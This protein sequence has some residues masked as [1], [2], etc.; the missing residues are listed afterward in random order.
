MN[1]LDDQVRHSYELITRYGMPQF[2]NSLTNLTAAQEWAA[3]ERHNFMDLR[4]R[5]LNQA[6]RDCQQAG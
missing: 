4:T 3:R 6:T 1:P 5:S 2:Q